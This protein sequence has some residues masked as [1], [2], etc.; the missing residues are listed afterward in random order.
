MN[1]KVLSNPLQIYERMIFDIRKAKSEIILETYI[2][3]NDRIGRQFRDELLLKAKEGV[4]IFLLIDSWGSNVKK[5][6]FKEIIR[7]G[8]K[9]RF[10]REFRY[11]L[12]IFSSNHERNH[13]KLL[14]VDRNI[15]YIGSINIT[16]ECLSW[17]EL[18]LRIKGNITLSF[19]KAFFKSWKRF[20]LW[21]KKRIHLISERDFEI[22]Q[23]FPKGKKFEKRFSSL[24]R[25]AKEEI[26]IVTPYFIPSKRI[27]N[28]ITR[29]VKRGIEIKIVL[30]K[31][32]NVF[33]LDIFRRRYLGKLYKRGVKIYYDPNFIHSKL[34]IIDNKFF[35]LG[36][37]N[38]DYRSFMHQF[39]INLLGYN[40][41]VI[42]SLRNY[43]RSLL[44]KCESFNYDL[45]VKR[46]PFARFRDFFIHR[47]IQPYLEYFY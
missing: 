13:R 31:S 43:F 8:G 19:R 16:S 28:A 18:V 34:L 42:L 26:C 3:G 44:L 37:S 47:I 17:E 11:T 25:G 14:L 2:F 4:R 30:P 27:R 10:F 46:H 39:E 33:L 20:N 21:D 6:F 24:I 7:Y 15:S 9:V 45:W 38:L 32:S 22:L 35:L 23:D 1:H 29:A 36:S 5:S 12:S 40:R 41:R